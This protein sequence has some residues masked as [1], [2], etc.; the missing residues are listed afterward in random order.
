MA[1]HHAAASREA[2]EPFATEPPADTTPML[3]QRLDLLLAS[4]AAAKRLGHIN[5]HQCALALRRLRL[6]AT[7]L[8]KMPSP[9]PSQRLLSAMQSI[10]LLL[11]Q[12]AS[13]GAAA[14][15]TPADLAVDARCVLYGPDGGALG[16]SQCWPILLCQHF[17]CRSFF[18]AAYRRLWA[19]W[20]MYSRAELEREDSVAESLDRA[21]D[22]LAMRELLFPIE[23][24]GAGTDEADAD[25]AGQHQ[26]DML[27]YYQRRDMSSWRIL[28]HEL[29]PTDQRV[30]VA[31]APRVAGELPPAT[32]G[33]DDDGDDDIRFRVQPRVH[34][35]SGVAVV[36]KTLDCAPAVRATGEA[37]AAL[38]AAA[39][40]HAA[41]FLLD[42][43]CR[44]TW[45]HPH[46]VPCLGGY[47]E[48]FAADSEDTAAVAAAELLLPW[49]RAGPT[50]TGTPVMTLGYVME[51]QT[52]LPAA[53]NASSATGPPPCITVHDLLYR[54]AAAPPRSPAVQR[55]HRFTLH[56]ALTI[57]D[58]VADAL[59]YVMD[60]SH[61]VSA[62]VQTAWFT[63]DPANIFIVRVVGPNGE[64]E[65]MHHHHH[66]PPP[67]APPHE[68]QQQ[69]QQQ[70][71][72]ASADGS[73][74][75]RHAAASP[76]VSTAGSEGPSV[77][78]DTADPSPPLPHQ[79]HPGDDHT[80]LFSARVPSS[81]AATPHTPVAVV[82]TAPRR[83]SIDG[84]DG[85]G[86]SDSGG[87]GGSRRFV[88]RY[89][90]P[91]RWTPHTVAGSRWRPHPRATAPASYAA[92][93]LFLALV[94]GHVP[95]AHLL[96]DAEVEERV[97]AVSRRSSASP[98]KLSGSGQGL[99]IP[100][101]LPPTVVDWCRRALSLD[102]G[103]PP[104]DLEA[105][106]G[107]I[108]TSLVG[109]PDHIL[110]SRVSRGG[111]AAVPHHGGGDGDA[112]VEMESH[113][114]AAT[115]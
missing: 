79:L 26:R 5:Q 76:S 112:E 48:R 13:D 47:T 67:S 33:S 3:L 1:D 41:E 34:R 82:N 99:R 104:F 25:G 80:A 71:P 90:P 100:P 78:T 56:E 60:D 24:A 83:G 81:T 31:A 49:Q 61:D 28:F 74:G 87:G 19:S 7:T 29:T 68:Q 23:P 42:V 22:V 10:C 2:H 54:T 53:S 51:L 30:P 8:R 57:C 84:G 115:P 17:S 95:Y 58:Q 55:R 14:A 46:L 6:I 103:Q 39:M 111:G 89:S 92:A 32:P 93:Q 96:T 114:S 62:A 97:F 98:V 20:S 109:T 15:D 4:S 106:R 37:A 88:V 44:A 52:V 38:E 101:S 113:T 45:C 108:A 107:A 70:S 9:A 73:H 40:E 105:L 18:R 43:G 72:R 85:D 12:C 35:L 66:P 69:Q 16:P 59:Q 50:N 77:F 21:A 110:H 63:V 11:R 65:D 27:A 75:A 64:E 86:D 94:T 102:R 36:L 91:C